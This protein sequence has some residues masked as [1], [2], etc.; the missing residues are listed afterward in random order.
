MDHA[1][2]VPPHYPGV[3]CSLLALA[4]ARALRGDW[5]EAADAVDILAE[6]GRVFED[7][8]PVVKAFAR[9]FRQLLR[10]YV[11]AIDEALE[12]LAADL[13][14]VVGTDTYSLAPLC[15]L[16]ELSDLRSAPSIAERPYQ[17]LSR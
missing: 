2:G 12:P 11:N 3:A 15:A 6:P 14:Q 4:C 8:G 1:D 10:A 5:A 7:P 13:L 16:V 9:V 17:A